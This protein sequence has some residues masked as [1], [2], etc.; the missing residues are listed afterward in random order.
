MSLGPTNMDEEHFLKEAKKYCKTEPECLQLALK[1][2]VAEYE[3]ELK[4]KNEKDERLNEKDERLKDK[5]ERLK[6]KDD[7]VN[8]LKDELTLMKKR[9]LEYRSSFKAVLGNRAIYE[10]ALRDW[11]AKDPKL[12]I[13]GATKRHKA[14]VSTHILDKNLLRQKHAKVFEDINSYMPVD[15]KI[16]IGKVVE[17]LYRRMSEELHFLDFDDDAPSGL[18]IGRAEPAAQALGIVMAEMQ[19]QGIFTQEVTLVN[20][21]GKA[22]CKLC[23]GEVCCSGM[24]QP[25][26]L[27]KSALKEEQ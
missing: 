6:D 22:V 9:E 3:S 26:R 24:E 12:S 19:K 5:D 18:Y 7:L 27:D 1:L 10:A 16:S 15:S 11:E 23:E 14:F 21:F 4:L 13:T 8:Q 17:D 25:G 2:A 20:Q